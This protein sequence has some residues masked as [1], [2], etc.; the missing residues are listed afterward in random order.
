MMGGSNF[1]GIAACDDRAG[2]LITWLTDTLGREILAFQFASE[3]A[4]FRRYFRVTEPARTFIVMD[5]PPDKMSTEPFIRIARKFRDLGLNTP[6]IDHFDVRRGF[7]MM[8]DFGRQTYFDVLDPDNA[9]ALYDAALDTLVQLQAATAAQAGGLPLYDAQLLR[10]EMELF[11]EWYLP[12]R[13]DAAEIASLD[14]ILNAIFEQLIAS[15]LEQPQVCVHLDYH[16]RNLMYRPDQPP[17]VIDFQD[18]RIGP[19]TYDLVS[20]LRDC[21]IVWPREKVEYWISR[22]MQKMRHTASIALPDQQQLMRWF[23]WMGLQRHIKV[24]GIFTRLHDRDQKARYLSDM[25]TVLSY[26][27]TV[28]RQYRELRPLHDLIVTVTRR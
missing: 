3:D 25:P 28:S 11:R 22:Y 17:G 5:A 14:E 4:S 15:A 21:Y 8:T 9:D 18:A 24:A 16:S 7:V 27:K 26:I 1:K 6:D 10:S 12:H 20:L 19:L 13:L 23:D 2:E